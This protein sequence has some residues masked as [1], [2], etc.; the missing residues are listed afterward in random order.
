MTIAAASVLTRRRRREGSIRSSLA[1]ARTEL[2]S[3]PATVPPAAVRSPIATA[4]ASSDLF[5]VARRGA[6][7]YGSAAEILPSLAGF[8]THMI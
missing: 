4:T 3:I 1:S 5:G 7:T 2:S 6:V 8:I